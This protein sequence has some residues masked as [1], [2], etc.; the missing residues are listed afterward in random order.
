MPIFRPSQR[1]LRAAPLSLSLALAFGG[2]VAASMLWAAP[3]AAQSGATVFRFDI[4]PGPLAAALNQAGATAGVLLSFDPALVANLRTAGL[5]GS[6]DIQEGLR[7]LLAGSGLEPVARSDGSYALRK[8]PVPESGVTTMRAV[9]VTARAD[10]E[11]ETATGPV[12]GYVARR[13]AS[14][15]KTDTPLLETPRSVTVV[16][17]DQMRDRG[18][19]NVEQA[20]AYTAGVQIA[21]WGND[22]RFD[23][24]TVRGFDVT[25]TADYRDGLRQTNTGWLSYFR[26]EPYGLERLEVLK[27]PNSVLFGQIS[28]GGMINRVSKRPTREALREVEVQVGSDD[29]YQAQGDFGGALT[30]NGDVSYRL[31]ALARDSESDVVG[32]NDDS[33][34][35]APALTWQV[36][37]RTRITLLAHAQHFETAGSPRPFQLPSGELSRFWP[38]DVDF[39]GLKQTQYVAGYEAEHRISDTLVLRQ[40]LRYGHVDTDNQYLSGTLDA[41]GDT[42]QRTT[43]GVYESMHNLS[44]DTSLESR[45]ATGAVQHKLIGGIDHSKLDGSIRYLSGSAPSISISDPDYHQSIARPSTLSVDQDVSGTNTGA[46]AMDQAQWGD[47]R[48]SA[49]VRRDRAEQT[50]KDRMAGSSS[51]QTDWKTTGSLGVLYML[52]PELAPYVSYATSFSPQFGTN[53]Y[54]DAYKPT[55]G[56]QVEA[57]IKYQPAGRRALLTA[58]VFHLVQQNALT[59]D[60]ANVNNRIQ[61][62]ETRSRGIELEASGHLLQRLELVA[63]YTLQDVDITRSNDGT[64]GRQPV[65]IPRQMASLWGKYSFVNGLDVGVGARWIGESYADSQNTLR[66][67]DYTLVDARIGYDL[68][69]MLHGA[70]VALRA[71]NLTDKAYLMCHDGYCYRGRGRLVMASLNYRW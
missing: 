33:L 49:G 11:A 60:P 18:V 56:K 47:W 16:T 68:G 36:S 67:D 23:Q 54:G 31:T 25:S 41:D 70:S 6:F 69:G 43:Y 30:E 17:A 9:L 4:A 59:R 21:A 35:F 46:Y 57:G 26:T 58:S 13:A 14:A 12:D 42:I 48:L 3:V 52:T 38:G 19:L 51:S 32:V 66:N 55:V 40:N 71:N 53:F 44:V 37:D 24:I 50:Q 20:V 10:A 65:G 15:S 5:Q 39:D 64:E 61:T 1:R 62:G 22:P 8:A 45:F 2:A 34:Y 63:A 28:P 7:R 29:H 27:G